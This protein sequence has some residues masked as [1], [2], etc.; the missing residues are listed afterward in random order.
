SDRALSVTGQTLNFYD[1]DKN[2]PDN[3]GFNGLPFGQIGT[4]GALVKTES[5]VLTREILRESYKS[6]DAVMANPEEPPYLIPSSPVIWPAEYPPTFR[7][8][9][10]SLAG[11]TY[12]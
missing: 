10:Q 11:Y 12:Q 6:K 7:T 1:F 9:L 5:L 8:Q 4:Y 3:D 2:Q